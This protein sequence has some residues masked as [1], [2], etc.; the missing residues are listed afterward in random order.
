[1]RELSD[2]G[3]LLIWGV[4]HWMVANLTGAHVPVT[5]RRVFE[6]LGEPSALPLIAALLLLAARD[7]DRPLVIHP[8]CAQELSPDEAALACAVA[9][10]ANS[11]EARRRLRCLGCEASAALLRSLAVLAERFRTQG[12]AVRGPPAAVVATRARGDLQIR[13]S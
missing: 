11:A 13:E 2:G 10:G 7:A 6:L 4:R 9:A 5:V 1:L 3:H 8:P 12:L